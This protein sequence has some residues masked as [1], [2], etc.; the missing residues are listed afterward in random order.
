MEQVIRY[1]TPLC[2]VSASFE[3]GCLVSLSLAAAHKAGVCGGEASQTAG[4]HVQALQPPFESLQAMRRGGSLFGPRDGGIRVLPPVRLGATLP[5]CAA[6]T[7]R[8]LEA[9]FSGAIPDCIPPTCLRGTTFRRAVWAELMTVPYGSVV[10][11]GELGRRVAARTGRHTSPRAVGQ[12][13][14]HNPIALVVP[15][16][17]VI[18]AHMRIGGYAYGAAMKAAL[19]RIEGVDI[20]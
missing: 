18:A 17:R 13:V 16:H 3:D 7:L 2:V 11:Y 1:V 14:G 12:A 20:H 5:P 4:G 15:C 9:Y 10:T 8:F 6:A 19:L